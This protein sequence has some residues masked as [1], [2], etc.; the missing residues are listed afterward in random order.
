M[1]FKN[2]LKKI[3]LDL[4][5]AF[6]RLCPIRKNKIILWANS[7]KHYG[8]SPKYIAEY[9]LSNYPGKFELVWVFDSGVEIPTSMPGAIR[10]VRYF[11]LNYLKE[12]HTAHFVICN[13][14]TGNSYLW[15][16]RKNQIYIQTWHSS[17]RL[18][19]IEK[20]AKEN[21]SESYINNAISDSLKIDLLISGCDFSTKIFTESF[22]YSGKVMKCGTPRC[23]IFFTKN[24]VIKQKVYEAFNID[25]TFKV[26]LYAPT[27]RN[28]NRAFLNNLDFS[29]L[30][31]ALSNK[32]GG[33][34]F[35]LYR[36]HPNI[37]TKYYITQEGIDATHYADMQELIVAADILVT[38]YSSCMFDMAVANKPCLLYTPD[39]EDYIN[40][41]RGLYFNPSDLPFPKAMSNEDLIRIIETF[42]SR[43]YR[44]DVQKFMAAN[45]CYE[46]GE[47]S[48]HVVDYIKQN[49]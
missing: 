32:F 5:I 17:L 16:K 42:D 38:D 26:L 40:N 18:K 8:C 43:Q 45:G 6:Y 28:N 31:S 44:Y 34:W 13:M 15:K 4:Y 24:N 33:K 2:Y 39:L 48:K 11:S 27:F 36:F 12:L 46:K 29:M 20:D 19:K 25:N 3:R 30:R 47:A 23:D 35:I 21:L 14:R 37:L 9:I 7:F 22:W 49:L 1:N 41:E 10:I